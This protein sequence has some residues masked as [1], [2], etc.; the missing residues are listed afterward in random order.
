MP[1]PSEPVLAW[2]RSALRKRDMNVA[3]LAEKVG[4]KRSFVAF[5]LEDN[6]CY[7]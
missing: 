3:A 4:E 5:M 2:F 6:G 7:R 1:R